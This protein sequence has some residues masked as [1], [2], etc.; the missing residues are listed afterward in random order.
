MTYKDYVSN[1]S[2]EIATYVKMGG[3]VYDPRRVVPYYEK[4]RYATKLY[5]TE[6][7]VEIDIEDVYRDCGIKF[8]RDY[9]NF[10]TFKRGLEK[11]ADEHGFVDPIKKNDAS[12]E[13]IELKSYLDFHA[14]ELGISPG[15]YLILMTDFRYK[16]LVV[17][18]DYVEHLKQRIQEEIPDGIAKNLKR[19]HSEIYYALKHFQKYSPEPISYDETLGYF[20]LINASLRG[21]PAQK[22]ENEVNEELLLEQ[23]KTDF[24]DK[25]IG[26]FS[27]S[28]NYKM[29]LRAARCNDQ[30]IGQ[31]LDSHGFNYSVASNV[32]RLSKFQVDATEHEQKLMPMRNELLQEYDTQNADDVDMFVINT[33]IAKRIGETLYKHQKPEAQPEAQNPI[34]TNF[35]Q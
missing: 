12:K 19:T 17:G 23:L 28:P 4:I 25:K 29:V 8:N 35:E 16:T 15:E 3:S 1:L 18:G 34:T 26:S 24:P 9:N 14:R 31:W 21:R 10:L 11:V 30:T 22:G 20:G 2:K 13:E 6:N 27:S 33:N 32:S 5:K 7:D